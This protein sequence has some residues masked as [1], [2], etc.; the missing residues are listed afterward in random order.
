[1]PWLTKACKD[2]ATTARAMQ[3]LIS[4]LPLPVPISCAIYHDMRNTYIIGPQC[5]GKTTLV[6]ALEK[7]FRH[8]T[9]GASSADPQQ[10]LIIREVARTVLKEKGFIR[11]D[12]TTS[13]TRALQL[14]QHILEAQHRAEA[15]ACASKTSSWFL[16]DR[17]GLDPIVYTKCFVGYEAVEELLASKTWLDLEARMKKSIVVLCEAGCHWLVDDGVRLM[18]NDLEEWT[19]VEAA[20]RDLLEKRGISYYII[21]KDMA[22]LGTRVRHVQA[23][24]NAMHD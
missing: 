14:Q 16:C 1:M 11:E 7:V 2:K 9:H 24:I 8:D 12:I 15:T 13:P 21:P 10:P 22:D 5:T 18:P 23:L 4:A 6:N 17:S 20:F 3:V 19:R